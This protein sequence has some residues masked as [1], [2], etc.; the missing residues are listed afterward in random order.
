MPLAVINIA[1]DWGKNHSAHGEHTWYHASEVARDVVFHYH[2][3]SG[4]LEEGEHTA[5]EHEAEQ[6]DDPE[7]RV[8]EDCTHVAEMEGFVAAAGV[9][10][11]LIAGAGIEAEIHEAVDDEEHECYTEKGSSE[12]YAGRYAAEMVGYG[13]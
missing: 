5:V 3:F 1:K 13:E 8:G 12:T 7:T 2:K 9:A 4:K 11:V 6:A 10:A